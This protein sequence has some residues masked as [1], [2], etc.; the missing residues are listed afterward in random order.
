VFLPGSDPIPSARRG[1]VAAAMSSWAVVAGSRGGALIGVGSGLLIQHLRFRH[2]DRTRWLD[3]RRELGVRFLEAINDAFKWLLNIS[4]MT[5]AAEHGL[6]FDVDGVST[7]DEAHRRLHEADMAIQRL[8]TELDI[9]GSE[10]QRKAAAR[11]R[12]AVWDVTTHREGTDEEKA[13]QRQ[14]AT[15]EYFAARKHFEATLR[16]GLIEGRSRRISVLSIPRR[17]RS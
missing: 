16:E 6:G 10:E 11:L 9:I 8:N 2:D 5:T 14:A 4:N 1:S 13:A 12:A 7:V 3:L 15:D 17:L